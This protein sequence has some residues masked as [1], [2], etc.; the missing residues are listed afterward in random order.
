MTVLELTFYVIIRYGKGP[1]VITFTLKFPETMGPSVEPNVFEVELAPLSEMPHTV[2][3]L[4][5]LID[6]QLFDGTS[7][8]SADNALIEGGSP[9]HAP[10]PKSVKLHERYAKFGYNRSPLGFNE[11][12]S[13]FPHKEFTIGFTGSPIAGPTLAI[14]MMDNSDVRGPDKH[15]RN[16]DPCFGKVISG[17]DTL[18]RIQNAPKAADGHRL[19]MNVEIETVRLKRNTIPQQTGTE[20]Q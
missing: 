19:A 20:Q 10:T 11:Y 3:T 5:D 13:E 8:V 18:Q 17:F 9:N 2:F 1:F 12:S 4:L 16:G 14:N 7:F 15:G 6:L